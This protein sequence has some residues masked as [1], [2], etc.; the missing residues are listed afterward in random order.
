MPGK[1]KLLDNRFTR[2]KLS[3]AVVSIVAAS[4]MSSPA[5]AQQGSGTVEEVVVTGIKGSMMRAMD[6]KRDAVGVVDAISAEDIG[7]FPDSNLAESLQRITGVSIDRTNG[8]GSEVTVRGF[9]GG[10]NLVTLNGRHMPAASVDLGDYS[11]GTGRSF[12]FANLASESVSALQVYKTGRAEIP[13]GGIGATINIETR[14]PLDN[15]GLDFSVGVKALHDTTNEKGDDVTPE[16]SGLFS[17][18]GMDDRIGVG[19]TASFQERHSGSI[20]STVNDWQTY[21]MG[22]GGSAELPLASGGTVTNL[23]AEG[24]NWSS[25]NDIRYHF[26]DVERDRT[27]AQLTLQFMPVD[28]ITLTGDVTYAENNLVQNRGDQT[29]WFNQAFNLIEYDANPAVHTPV[30]VAEN[31][32]GTKDTGF[33]Q[34]LRAIDN[35]LESF[36][37]NVDWQISDRLN[38]TFDAHD[39]TMESLP[40]GPNN[41]SSIT[42]SMAGPVV[43]SQRVEYGS[44]VP[45]AS[46]VFNDDAGN[47]NGVFD[48]GDMGSQLQRLFYSSQTQEISQFRVD[49][50]YEFDDGRFDFGVES[51]AIEMNQKFKENQQVLGD[52]GI[53]N[54]GE[55]PEDMI[56]QFCLTCMFDEADVKNETNQVAW[57]GDA[58]EL[59]R[60]GAEQYGHEFT[61]NI[62]QGFDQNHT[63]E[64]DT[65]SAY[66]QVTLQG[67]LG[68]M[69]TN[70]VTGL[71][72]EETDVTSTSFV[73]IPERITWQDN[74]DF[75]LTRTSDVQ[76][77]VKE[78]KYNNLLPSLDF[79]INVTDNLKGRFSFSQTIARTDYSN[80]RAADNPTTPSAPIYFGAV[81]DASGGNPSLVPLQ[82]DNYDVSLEWYYDDANYA[83]IAFFEK[84]VR[85]FVGTETVDEPLFGLRDASSGAEGTRSGDAAALLQQIGA[86]LNQTT[87]FAMTAILDNPAQYPDPVAAFENTTPETLAAAHDVL[88]NENDPLFMFRTARPVNNREASINGWEL[89]VQHFFGETGFGVQANYTIVR[90]DVGFDNAAAPDEDQFALVGLSDTANLALMYENY[91]LSARVA[92]NWRDEFLN[93]TS[94]GSYRNP[95]YTEA[96]SQLD[97]NVSYDVTDNISVTFEGINILDETIRQHARTDNQMWFYEEL[98]A[99]YLLGARYAF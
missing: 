50:G 40:G 58:A 60:W 16:I 95:S 97:L 82:S 3:R 54:P 98:G 92:Y 19:L 9:G 53:T 52:W 64:E 89:A 75:L 12:D 39:S 31:I 43:S 84:R 72:Y 93:S 2:T 74:N 69:E 20:S 83:S 88:P 86:E 45:E 79:D 14:R 21:V 25:P 85:N 56:E 63:V 51:R 23:P 36:G 76:A 5:F 67:E 41:T 96:Y 6:I 8:E 44:G 57:R 1:R 22:T 30:V 34:Q 24:D 90:G 42:F 37:F 35:T 99:R 17:W 66:V 11:Q 61:T 59:A 26:A 87:L 46:Y 81:A 13:T 91:G 28:N 55:I 38:L 65:S 68:G 15:P 94:A 48:K 29:L 62:D 47:A 32:N 70:L 77:Y 4:A 33:E 71:R 10:N 78:S 49:G 80:L 27:N 73:A 7:K 18:T